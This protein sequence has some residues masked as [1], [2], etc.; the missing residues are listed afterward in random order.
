MNKTDYLSN[1][2]ETDADRF[3]CDYTKE[4][5]GRDIIVQPLINMSNNKK[6]FMEYGFGSGRLLVE[7]SISFNKVVGF[8]I[9]NT[10]IKNMTEF[11]K[12]KN[13]KNIELYHSDDFNTFVQEKQETVDTLLSV[14]VLEHVVDPYGLL[15]S[16]YKLLNKDGTLIISVPNVGY[17]KHRIHLMMGKLPKTGTD[18]DYTN[19]RTE[20]WD[21]NHLHYF[22]EDA[23]KVILK[24]CGF[25]VIKLYGWGYK[26]NKMRNLHPGLLSGEIIAVCKK[27]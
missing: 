16:F 3:S 24:D 8:E 20:G 12:K 7:N 9:S 21:G 17:L 22:T 6:S 11:I 25:K 2:Y 19:W 13:I 10:L 1:Y 15:D 23:F 14:A 18:E 26:L 5:T 4:L 27:I